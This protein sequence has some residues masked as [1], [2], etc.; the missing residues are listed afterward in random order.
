MNAVDV[1][2][3]VAFI[4]CLTIEIV[5]DEQQWTYQSVKHGASSKPTSG[6]PKPSSRHSYCQIEDLKRGFIAGGLFK[7]SRHPNFACEQALW[8]V[9]YGFGGN[10][11]V[12]PKGMS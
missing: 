10:A 9:L 6:A 4:T 3:I 12:I 11:T 8:Y 2:L 7:Y 5:A 1:L